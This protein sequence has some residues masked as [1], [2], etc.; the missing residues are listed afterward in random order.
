MQNLC[1]PV[2]VKPESAA[3]SQ[4]SHWS[5]RPGRRPRAEMESQETCRLYSA[6]NSRRPKIKDR[7]R[8]SA[9]KK[10]KA[11]L[12]SFLLSAAVLAGCAGTETAKSETTETQTAETQMTETQA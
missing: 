12:A 8:R 6:G 11:L 2:T 5:V 4:D 1:E 7:K 10:N 3:G 9:M